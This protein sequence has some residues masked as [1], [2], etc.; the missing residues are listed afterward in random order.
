MPRSMR[1]AT[2]ASLLAAAAMLAGLPARADVLAT[3]TRGTNI[4]TVGL[5]PLNEAG[6]TAV[7]FTTTADR[8]KVVI[9][10]NADC[11]T[12]GPLYVSI[13][14]DGAATYPRSG[15]ILLC[16]SNGGGLFEFTPAIRQVVYTPPKKG[17]HY[18]SVTTRFVGASF[19]FDLR[20][21]SLVVMK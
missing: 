17:T 2:L 5:L 21:T 20:N 8:Q 7:A 3:S 12:G 11:Y 15:G 4:T 9:T 19:S 13:T 14:V 6:N 10:Y 18:V 16:T 1:N